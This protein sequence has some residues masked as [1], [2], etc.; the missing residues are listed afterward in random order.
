MRR[1]VKRRLNGLLRR[2]RH[3]LFYP[4]L[5]LTLYGLVFIG[6]VYQT[7]EVCAKYFKYETTTHVTME[8][9]TDSLIPRLDLPVDHKFL[10]GDRIGFTLREVFTQINDQTKLLEVQVQKDGRIVD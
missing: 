10:F 1:N 2:L 8:T 6:F 7:G 9:T 4:F 5:R 3:H